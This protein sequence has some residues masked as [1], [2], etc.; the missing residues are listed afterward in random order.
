MPSRRRRNGPPRV[1]ITQ[2]ICI[3]VTLALL[4]GLF[5]YSLHH[6]KSQPQPTQQGSVKLAPNYYSTGG[7]G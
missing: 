3:V 6:D 4:V 7:G 1:T 5:L 2:I